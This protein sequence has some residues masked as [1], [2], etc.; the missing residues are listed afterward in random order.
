MYT[1]LTNRDTCCNKRIIK[2]LAYKLC[3]IHVAV[4]TCHLLCIGLFILYIFTVDII[5]QT[6]I[7]LIILEW[8]FNIIPSQIISLLAK[9]M[10][11]TLL[12]TI[13]SEVKLL[14]N[15]F[16]CKCD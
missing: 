16:I 9:A 11:L 14:L 13:S 10:N 8:C 6:N 2:S 1:L 3:G 5:W 15:A 12:L 4:R 7:I